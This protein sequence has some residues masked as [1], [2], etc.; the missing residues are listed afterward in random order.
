MARMEESVDSWG[1]GA[2]RAAAL[3]EGNPEAWEKIGLVPVSPEWREDLQ[4]IDDL[5]VAWY[6]VGNIRAES[7][8]R[9]VGGACIHRSEGRF[10]DLPI[11]FLWE[12][13]SIAMVAKI[14]CRPATVL[15]P[16]AEESL[17]AP[18]L[19][20]TYLGL[21]GEKRGSWIMWIA[22]SFMVFF[23][24]SVRREDCGP[25]PLEN[26]LKPAFSKPM[27][28]TARD[29]ATSKGA[30]RPTTWWSKEFM[31]RNPSFSGFAAGPTTS[32]Q[33]R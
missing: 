3:G 5:C 18:G 13:L 33:F 24:P 26:P 14:L 8:R 19:R 31:S 10:A 30:F 25:T 2:A 11:A 21:A 7:I 15:L 27:R 9:V 20:E 1:G 32:R 6:G 23:T 22:A 17:R 29:T 12:V 28:A 16:V 4:Q